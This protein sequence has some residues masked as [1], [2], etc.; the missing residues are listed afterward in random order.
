MAAEYPQ[1]QGQYPAWA[2]LEIEAAGLTTDDFAALDW[3]DSLEPG[4]VRA[5]GAHKRGRT[6]GEYDCDGKFKLFLDAA[7]RFEKTLAQTNPSIGLVVFDVVGHW[8]EEDGGDIREIQLEGC[9][10]TKRS[11]SNAPGTDATAVEYE[12]DVM[13][14]RLDSVTLLEPPSPG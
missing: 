3:S 6:R 13:I 1:F 7:R 10:I 11:N 2:S 12:L 8:S 9:R 14:V 5:I 4:I